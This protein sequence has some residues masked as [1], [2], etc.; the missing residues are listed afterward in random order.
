V[1]GGQLDCQ[2]KSQA[3][4]EALEWEL[5]LDFLQQVT[6]MENIKSVKPLVTPEL[7]NPWQGNEQ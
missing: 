7:N 3:E 4:V 6:G 2:G 5:I 1:A